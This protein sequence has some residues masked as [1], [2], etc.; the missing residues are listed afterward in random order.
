MMLDQVR[1]EVSAKIDRS[2][3]SAFGQFMTPSSVARFMANLFP[4]SPHKT[5]R[6]LDAGAGVGSLLGAFL[7]RWGQGDFSF[8]HVEVTA[9]EIDDILRDRLSHTLAHYAGKLDI[10][11]EVLGTDFIEDA[12]NRIQFQDAR[13]FTHAIL[14]PPYKKIASRSRHRLLLRQTGIEGDGIAWQRLPILSGQRLVEGSHPRDVRI[15]PRI[16]PASRDFH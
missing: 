12:V 9:Y 1:L 10:G 5:A 15:I 16:L 6:L 2:R 13:R 14:N 4:A 11:A 3:R 8:R 7:D